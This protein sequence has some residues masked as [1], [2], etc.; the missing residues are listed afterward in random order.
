MNN[1]NP[2][3]LQGD[4]M[5]LQILEQMGARV[6]ISGRDI[7]V[8][9]PAGALRG[10]EV[11]MADCPDLVPTVAVLAAFAQGPTRIFG[12]AHLRIKESDRIAAPAAE[13]ARVGCEVHE[14]EDGLIIIPPARLTPPTEP[15]ET[16]NDHR[17]AMSVALFS[18]AG[19]EVRIK[20]PACVSKS[21]P[22]F[23]KRW[24]LI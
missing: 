2:A 14:Q 23:W 24:E 4:R 8:C 7:E 21:F 15:F 20:N 5:I 6:S 12:V 22:D 3:S 19:F 16:Y 17:M 10:I 18:C 1:L 9:A 11:N 13:L